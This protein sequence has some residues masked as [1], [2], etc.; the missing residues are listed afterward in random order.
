M[1]RQIS[2]II[3]DQQLALTIFLLADGGRAVYWVS[4]DV[5]IGMLARD[6]PQDRFV[7]PDPLTPTV[8]LVGQTAPPPGMMST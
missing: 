6:N 2:E 5:A 8:M 3:I 1:T 4:M 7:L